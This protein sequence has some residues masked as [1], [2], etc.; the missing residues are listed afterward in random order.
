[1][2]D[3]SFP[4]AEYAD[5]LL[6]KQVTAPNKGDVIPRD[7]VNSMLKPHQVDAVA[8][9][10]RKGCAAIFASFGLGK[11]FMQLEIVRLALPVGGRGLIVLPL[12]VRQE[13]TRDAAKLGI[14]VR[15]IRRTEEVNE[16]GIYLTN[17]E[18]VRDGKLNPALFDAASLD[19]AAILRG[20]GGSKTFREFMRLFEAVPRRFVATAT[21]S[22]NE[23]IELLAYAAFLG[24]MDVGQAK[25]RFFKRDSTNADRLTLHPHKAQE[26]WLWV[27]SWALFIVTPSDLGHDDTGYALPPVE[28]HWHEVPSDHTGAGEDR[29]GQ[30]RM[31]RNAAI[32]VSAAASEK[33]ES[34]SA[35]IGKMM[36]LRAIDPGAHRILWHDLEDERRAIEAAVPSVVSVYGSLDL[37]DRERAIIGFSDG[38]FPELAGKPSVAGVGCNFQRHCAWAI[39]LGIGFKFHDFIQAVHRVVRFGQTRP[40]RIDL[41]YTEAERDVRR[42]L[43]AKWAA[44]N[45]LV[46]QMRGIVREHGLAG[47][48]MQ[49]LLSRAM[50]VKRQEASGESWRIVNNDTVPETAAM[51]NSSVDLIVTSIPFAT[52]YEYTPTYNDFGHTDDNAH[53][54]RQMDFLSPQ[55][56]RVLRPG[57]VFACHVKDRIIPGGMTGLGFQTLYPFHCDAIAHYQ[58]HGFA[59]LGM[60]TVTTD[61]VRE[62]NQTYRLG[63]SEQCKD[64]SR[65]GCGVPEYVLLFRKPPSDPTSGYADVRVEKDKPL[66]TDAEG[67]VRPFDKKT[68]WRQPVPGTGYSR[69]KWQLD[70]HGYTRSS[71]DRLL[72]AD[73]LRQMAHEQMYKWWEARSMER[74]YD[75]R[76]H[77]A[78]CERLDEMERLPATFMLWPPHSVHPD[79]WTDITRMRT[80]NAEQS[81]AGREMHLCPLQFDIVD[82]LIT[83]FCMPGETVFD[84]FSGIGTVPLRAMKL[85]RR[86][87]GN[88]LSVAYWRD[89]VQYCQAEQQKAAT[90]SLF[91][92]L[93]AEEAA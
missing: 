2:L 26:F 15:F 9:A 73:E 24:V 54:W 69:A 17:Y 10:V 1:M 30:A 71:G 28:V 70:A 62:N 81:Q 29:D 5:F 43:E 47:A 7:A 25:T 45:A 4:A 60:K 34:L 79:V 83:Q 19:E 40:V 44:H 12:G 13:F 92:L 65:M 57:R 64:G 53:F 21:P 41:I 52:Q 48:A 42:A 46:E 38:E 61:V 82:R 39:F 50:G 68:N 27:A 66:C 11:T 87:I 6:A 77:L 91:D 58:K 33:R 49:Q 67:N 90:P 3:H 20:F 59:F 16:P 31:F 35:R 78:L 76:E 55:L 32:G 23:Y 93:D 18:S 36:E 74:V 84:P 80:L 37:E 89:A 72:S 22:P 51:P 86:G 14:A 8:W 88:E 75:Y 56:L 63:W 85:G